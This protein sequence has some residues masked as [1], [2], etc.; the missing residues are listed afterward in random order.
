MQ[1]D[2]KKDAAKDSIVDFIE[3][4]EYYQFKK[5]KQQ[6]ENATWGIYIFAIVSLLFYVVFLL[7]RHNDF[8]WLFFAINIILIAV[9]FCLAAFSHYKPY[10]AF[11]ATIC[12]LTIIFLLDA[13]FTSQLNIRG[14]VIKIILAVYISMRLK[15]AQRVQLYENKNKK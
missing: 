15:A 10:N 5:D 1:M 7:I 3:D 9:Y 8:N 13:F 6:I 12:F 14:T 11:I 2:S 4:D